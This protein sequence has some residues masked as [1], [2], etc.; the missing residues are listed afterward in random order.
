MG[1]RWVLPAST[2]NSVLSVIDESSTASVT[3]WSGGLSMTTRSEALAKRPR[4]VRIRCDPRS[5]AGLGG[6]GPVVM[7]RRF[8]CSVFCATS[9]NVVASVRSRL[10]SPCA[11]GRSKILWIAW[12]AEVRVQE[13]RPA[14]RLREDDR[15]VR[16]GRRLAL[17]RDGARDEQGPNRRIDRGELDAR[18]QAP[19]GLRDRPEVTE[20]RRQ[21]V[22]L[23]AVLA[24]SHLRDGPEGGKAGDRLHVLRRLDGVVQVVE[25]EGDSERKQQAHD[26][27]EEGVEQDARRRWLGRRRGRVDHGEQVGAAVARR[28]RA[29]SRTSGGG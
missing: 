6:S 17:A 25:H 18:A 9:S 1:P 13:D 23:T 5:S 4:I 16:R 10:D 28:S 20:E 11:F 19:I 24:T 15:D 22:D 29:S 26:R 8:S 7:T 12:L 27:R 2:T 21:P 14:A 3:A